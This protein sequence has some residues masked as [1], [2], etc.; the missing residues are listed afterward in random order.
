MA[1]TIETASE[2][3]PAW[4]EAAQVIEEV[5]S[6]LVALLQSAMCAAD[7]VLSGTSAAAHI[8]ALRTLR[9]DVLDGTRAGRKLVA[10]FGV[11]GAELAQRIADGHVKRAEVAKLING[12]EKAVRADNGFAEAPV[13]AKVVDGGLQLL[14][15]LA[16][17]A[18]PSFR[19][20]VERAQRD[21]VEF[22]DRSVSEG[23]AV[24][25]KKRR[26]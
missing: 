5:S 10:L 11:H 20:A 12:W 16:D 17:G 25:N 6:G 2:F 13:P 24:L 8:D 22:R 19:R 21:L 26:F 7:S 3:Q 9:D 14:A 1:Y 23:L 15:K 4:P 18:S